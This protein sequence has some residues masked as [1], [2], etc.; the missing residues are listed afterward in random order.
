[1]ACVG[2][3]GGSVAR[4][5]IV[6]DKNGRML[7][8]SRG[9]VLR[10]I[11]HGQIFPGDTLKFKG[12]GEEM[13]IG[14]YYNQLG[15]FIAK[16]FNNP[17]KHKNLGWL[18]SCKDHHQT[19]RRQDNPQDNELHNLD[20]FYQYAGEWIQRQFPGYQYGRQKILNLNMKD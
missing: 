13:L 20:I 2:S 12:T 16:Q 6:P 7:A 1:M 14:L 4:E 9:I 5:T 3:L 18:E 11:R 10:N 17:T 8:T 15:Y 19:S